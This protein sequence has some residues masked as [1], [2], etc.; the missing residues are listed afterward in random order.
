VTI[1]K[2][3]CCC[4]N[5]FLYGTYHSRHGANSKLTSFSRKKGIPTSPFPYSHCHF[6][7]EPR[8]S[9]TKIVV[10]LFFECGILALRARYFH[11]YKC[12][13][14]FFFKNKILT[15]TWRCVLHIYIL[16]FYNALN[17]YYDAANSKSILSFE[18]LKYNFR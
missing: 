14:R 3:R 10:F 2:C 8:Y 16:L 6:H 9:I 12:I 13:C 5:H 7:G 11:K 4:L 1:W 15:Y 18:N 17:Q